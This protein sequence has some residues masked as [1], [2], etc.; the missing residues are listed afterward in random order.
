VIGDAPF[1][2]TARWEP[3]TKR[4]GYHQGYAKDAAGAMKTDPRANSI[5]K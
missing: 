4:Q 3:F 2:G 5:A 1:G